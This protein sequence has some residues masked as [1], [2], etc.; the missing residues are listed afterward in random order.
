ME[1]KHGRNG[2]EG[3]RESWA[4]RCVES[5]DGRSGWYLLVIGFGILG[6]INCADQ[7]GRG[8]S[9]NLKHNLEV[10]LLWVMTRSG[11]G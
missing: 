1:S 3:M 2:S 4:M 5:R 6:K 9:A 8:G 10:I 11:T 7:R